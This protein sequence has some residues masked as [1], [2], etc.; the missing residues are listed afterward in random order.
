MTSYFRRSSVSFSSYDSWIYSSRRQQNGYDTI[1]VLERLKVGY[2]ETVKVLVTFNKE[3]DP[4]MLEELKIP[5]K[6]SDGVIQRYNS[7]LVVPANTDISALPPGVKI[8]TMRSFAFDG[9]DLV[10][11]KNR[12][13]KFLMHP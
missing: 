4:E 8:H 10:W 5:E 1:F 2:R 7:A 9:K 13:V 12:C 6:V 11:I 3:I